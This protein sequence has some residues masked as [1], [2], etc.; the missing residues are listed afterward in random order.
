MSHL[1][2]VP[3]CDS[4]GRHMIT[5]RCRRPDTSAI[6]APSTGAYL[7]DQHSTHGGDIEAVFRPRDDRILTTI[8]TAESHGKRGR[9]HERRMEVTQGARRGYADKREQ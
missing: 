8:V 7:C 1:C 6:W 9:A 5:V 3:D 2:I 4:P